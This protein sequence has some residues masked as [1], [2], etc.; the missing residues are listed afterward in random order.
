MTI[1]S[2]R[3]DDEIFKQIK[4]FPNYYVSDRGRVY[5]QATKRFV[6]STGVD[7]FVRVGLYNGDKKLNISMEELVLTTFDKPKPFPWFKIQHIDGCH[8]NNEIY[9]LEWIDKKKYIFK[10]YFQN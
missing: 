2:Y 3:L 5:N 8:D 7:G 1:T 10:K 9:N 4:D 6:G